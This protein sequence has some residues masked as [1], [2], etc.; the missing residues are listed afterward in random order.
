VI[1]NL[2]YAY[3]QGYESVHLGVREKNLNNG[4]K[5]HVRLLSFK[6]KYIYFFMSVRLIISFLFN[7]IIGLFIYCFFCGAATQRASWPPHSQGF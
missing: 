5:R 3:P 7:P 6:C 1:P 4:G 2:G